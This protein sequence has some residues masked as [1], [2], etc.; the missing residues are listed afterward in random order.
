[1]RQCI[2]RSP[3]ENQLN[4]FSVHAAHFRHERSACIGRPPALPPSL[5][6]VIGGEIRAANIWTRRAQ[7]SCLL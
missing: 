5:P 2:Q 6:L 3:I 4:D 1:M 7:K